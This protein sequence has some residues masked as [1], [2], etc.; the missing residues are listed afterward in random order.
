M[1][2]ALIDIDGRPQWVALDDAPPP[3]RASWALLRTRVVDEVTG[4]PPRGLYAL[5]ATPRVLPRVA[6]GGVVGLV[7]RPSAAAGAMLR[8][9]GLSC[10][11]TAPGY[12][13][14]SLDAAIDAARRL[15][16]SGA[17]VSA[18]TLIVAPPDPDPP[19]AQFRPGRGVL[20]ERTTDDAPDGFAVVD[21]GPAP[22]VPTDVPIAPPLDDARPLRLPPWRLTGVPIVLPEQPLHR[23]AP[24]IVLGRAMRQTAPN[25]APVPALATDFTLAIVGVW[26]TQAEVRAQSNPPHAPDLLSLGTPFPDDFAAG[27][28]LQACS[29]TAVASHGLRA[30]GARGAR[31]LLIHPWAGLAPAGGE[32]LQLGDGASPERELVV[33]AAFV[34][35]AEAALPARVPLVRSLAF[36]Q[37]ATIAVRRM[38]VATAVLPAL[39]REAQRGDRVLF[40]AGSL[41]ALPTDCVICVAPGTARAAFLVARNLPRFD[42]GGNA[43]HAVPLDVSGRFTLPPLGRLARLRLQARHLNQA[44]LPSLDLSLDPAAHTVLP[45]LFTP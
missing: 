26:W 13:P 22:A 45:I 40:A 14:R 19:R 11:V 23:A 4:E 15:L 32:L 42:G 24:A 20:I 16:T 10:E 27:T 39:A 37:A 1:T 2:R 3:A 12:L 25:A 18:S 7:G 5:S 6:E 21:A 29:L 44:P 8:A 31:E 41:V 9:G 38:T 43:V 17:A 28:P 33:T 35:P 30:A 34:P 36:P